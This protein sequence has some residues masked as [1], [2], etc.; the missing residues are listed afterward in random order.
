MPIRRIARFNTLG[1]L[2]HV[3]ISLDELRS[4][5]YRQDVVEA[6][7]SISWLAVKKL[8]YFGAD[9]A[10]YLGVTNTCVT[11]VVASGQ[12]LD[13]DDLIRKL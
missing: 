5:S 8:G 3:N 7:R 9:A 11:R 13:I 1:I 12:K 2:H 6:R 4:D 10:R